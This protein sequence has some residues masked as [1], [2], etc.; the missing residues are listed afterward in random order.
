MSAQSDSDIIKRTN[1]QFKTM[2]TF[3]FL[4]ERRY[5]IKGLKEKKTALFY[6]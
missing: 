3:L 6:W 4:K 5:K 1:A 2:L